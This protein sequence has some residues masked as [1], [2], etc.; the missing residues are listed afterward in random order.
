VGIADQHERAKAV[1]HEP[2]GL[3]RIPPELLIVTEHDPS[4]L[5]GLREP[6]EV[7]GPLNE[8]IGVLLEA[9]AG[10]G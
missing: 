6:D 2:F 3:S 4:V 10:F 7:V 8:V 9:D 1:L 5:A